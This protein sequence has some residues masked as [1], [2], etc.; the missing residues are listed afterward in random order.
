MTNRLLTLA[1]VGAV[2]AGSV[3]TVATAHQ[4]RGK[5]GTARVQIATVASYASG[6]LTVKTTDGS[7]ITGAVTR[8]T[9]FDCR[10]LLS[11]TTPTPTPTTPADTTPSTTPSDDEGHRGRRGPGN[12][13]E[14]YRASDDEDGAVCDT[15]SLTAGTGVIAASTELTKTGQRFTRIVLVSAT[16][17][18][19]SDYTTS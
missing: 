8:R 17:S 3:A 4:G 9:Q 13:G 14:R 16:S 12:R 11:T 5:A 1:V 18:S 7:T 10:A 19:D 6:T 2:G 15:T